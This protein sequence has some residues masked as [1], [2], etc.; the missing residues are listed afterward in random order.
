MNADRLWMHIGGAENVE[1]SLLCKTNREQSG[2]ER[3]AVP[4][5]IENPQTET[6]LAA[7]NLH[8]NRQ[9]FNPQ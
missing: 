5:K 2:L 4:K 6:R 8:R 1:Q 3:K 7:K 9:L